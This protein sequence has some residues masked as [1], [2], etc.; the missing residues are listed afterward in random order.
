MVRAETPA[1]I[2]SRPMKKFSAFIILCVAALSLAACGH[3]TKQKLGLVHTSPDEFTVMHRAPLAMPPDYDLRPPQPGAPRPQDA[4]TGANAQSAVF[5]N[6]G[7]QAGKPTASAKADANFLAA[8]GATQTDPNI[9][10]EVDHETA[11]LAPA[12]KPVVK[13]LLNIGKDQPPAAS[14]VDPAAEAAR[15]KQAAQN[16]QPPSAGGA[17]PSHTE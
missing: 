3:D 17:T 1:E 6:N 15:I 11:A 14:V 4:T 12:Q 2:I 10:P 5:G 16:G 9:R 13:K 8:A 7:S